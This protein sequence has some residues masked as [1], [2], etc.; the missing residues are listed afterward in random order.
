LKNHTRKEFSQIL[1]VNA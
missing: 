1:L